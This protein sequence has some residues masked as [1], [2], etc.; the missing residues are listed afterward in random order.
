ME[1]PQV[2]RFINSMLR[3]IWVDFALHEIF[4]HGSPPVNSEKPAMVTDPFFIIVECIPL[5]VFF[6]ININ[7]EVYCIIFRLQST[8]SN[9]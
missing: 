9:R 7:S 8:K 2:K 6:R 4:H 5:E 3:V 1:M